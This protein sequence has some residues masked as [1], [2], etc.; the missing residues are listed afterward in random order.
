MKEARDDFCGV[1]KLDANFDRSVHVLV[2]LCCKR[3]NDLPQAIKHLCHVIRKFPGYTDA[4]LARGQLY[5]RTKEIDKALDDFGVV[6]H[7][8]P[9]LIAAHEG[10]GQAHRIQKNYSDAEACLAKAIRLNPQLASPRLLRAKVYCDM[11]DHQAA[12]AD[13]QTLVVLD[14]TSAE[15]QLEMGK[16]HAKLKQHQAV[17]V[18]LA[19]CLELAEQNMQELTVALHDRQSHSLNLSNSSMS[20]SNTVLPS[21]TQLR[22][23]MK[24][25]ANVAARAYFYRGQF[26]FDN[27]DFDGACADFD[28]AC[29]IATNTGD[30]GEKRGK[31]KS[32][33]V[34]KRK[35]KGSLSE[36]GKVLP[37][38]WYRKIATSAAVLTRSL[39]PSCTSAK[40]ATTGHTFQPVLEIGRAHV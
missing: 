35:Q 19:C 22:A 6:A 8:T 18:H 36:H 9:G 40:S 23:Q 3:Q 27:T 12:L 25:Q 1:L 26:R 33:K 30:G 11:G 28:S 17:E 4:R 24:T 2:S 31:T 29:S 20:G 14:S 7:R 16:V 5:L 37:L 15:A 38:G 39:P 34:R 32:K 10:L 13:L 21:Q